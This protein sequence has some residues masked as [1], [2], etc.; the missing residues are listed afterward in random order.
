MNLYWRLYNFWYIWKWI[1]VRKWHYTKKTRYFKTWVEIGGDND[2]DKREE[3]TITDYLSVWG[4]GEKADFGIFE[5][6]IGFGNIHHNGRCWTGSQRVIKEEYNKMSKLKLGQIEGMIYA[7]KW[8]RDK[9]IF[10]LSDL[11][12]DRLISIGKHTKESWNAAARIYNYEYIDR[13]GFS[14]KDGQVS[15]FGGIYIDDFK[16]HRNEFYYITK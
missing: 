5:E 4:K 3:I 16:I 14:I 13:L 9:K 12:R 15:V 7:I 1:F 2:G 11:L 8:A 6:T 10:W